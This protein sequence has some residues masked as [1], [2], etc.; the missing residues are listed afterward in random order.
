MASWAVLADWHMDGGDHMDGGWAFVMGMLM[1]LVLAA[2]ILLVVWVVRSTASN[3]GAAPG[4][5]S[6]MEV[7]DRRLASGDITPEDYRERAEILR[8]R[9]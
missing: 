2:V 1:L 8:G 7:L 4:G 9:R 5:E 3:A 6:P